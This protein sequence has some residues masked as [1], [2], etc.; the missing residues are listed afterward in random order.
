MASD[1]KQQMRQVAQSLKT[2]RMP[3]EAHLQEV[4]RQF[5]PRRT[6]FSKGKDHRS[7]SYVNKELVNPR[8]LYALRVL[9]SGM[10]GGMTSP[11]RPWFRLLAQDEAQ[12]RDAV[13]K[14]H[15]D[16]AQKEMRHIMQQSGMYNVLH[17]TWGD[18]GWCGTDAMI[19][20]PDDRFVVRATPLV[21]GEYWLGTNGRGEV[22]TCYREFRMTT[23][24]IVGKFVYKNVPNG[25]PDWSVVPHSLK[26]SW[27][28]GNVGE[29]HDVAHLI[30]PRMDRDPRRPFGGGKPIAS[31]YWLHGKMDGD[32]KRLLGEFG[33]DRNP[34]VASRWDVEGYDVYG[35]SPAMDTLFAAKSLQVQERDYAEAVRRV[36]RPPM[37]APAELRNSG[38]SLMPE[39]VNFMADPSKGLV[40][41]YQVN[42]PLQHLRENIQDTEQ[43]IDEGMYANLFL[44]IS[45][46]QRREITAREIDERHEE[47]LLGLGPVIERQHAEKLGPVIRQVYE[48][49][50]DAG[51]IPSLPEDYA[52]EPVQIDYISMLAQA[53]KAIAT[54]GVERLYGF[55]GNLSAADQEVLDI[56]DN[57]E[58]VRQYADMLGVPGSILRDEQD[59]QQRR[60]ERREAVAAQNTVDQAAELAPAVKQTAD[61]AKVIAE[62]DATGRP[63]DILRNL[64]LK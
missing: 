47:K 9:Q 57:D 4:G 33:Y 63:V 53:Q 61:A 7:E 23:K 17:T 6:R 31:V 42:P 13:M 24:Q 32:D 35:T 15:L 62:T 51:R 40:P 8:P 11:A 45:R 30:T 25:P 43:R 58:A 54:G 38:F 60:D 52:D 5:K 27:D 18:L 50:I 36:N 2:L 44:M 64:G 1:T 59:V 16:K 55:L 46:L 21:P 12:R 39:A 19:V 22:D 34:L 37:N 49:A 10:H 14:E 56:T 26:K 48:L 3:Y 20:E 28:D 29:L 41:S